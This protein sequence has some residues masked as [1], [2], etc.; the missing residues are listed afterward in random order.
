[1]CNRNAAPYVVTKR[2][3]G[4]PCLLPQPQG[5]TLTQTT[6]S[7]SVTETAQMFL[8]PY[9]WPMWR[10]HHVI[11]VA[12]YK[13]SEKSGTNGNFIYYLHYMLYT[14]PRHSTPVV[15]KLIWFAAHCKTYN[16]FLAH[17]V[18]KTENILI[19]LYLVS[20]SNLN[21]HMYDAESCIKMD[22]AKT[23]AAHLATA[24][25]APFENHCSTHFLSCITMFVRILLNIL[26]STVAQESVILCLRWRRS[27][28]L[29]VYAVHD[30]H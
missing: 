1:M 14:F 25:G 9:F 5:H 13:L 3:D 18:Y 2:Q 22:K 7:Y 4:S 15:L 19:Y 11:R 30:D 20:W 12:I 26:R 24:G 28:I 6:S 10:T 29:T 8:V 21:S 16:N 23:F 27:R 17:F